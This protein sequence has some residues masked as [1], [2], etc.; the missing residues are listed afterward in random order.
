MRFLIHNLISAGYVVCS[1]DYRMI[2]RGGRIAE[3][4]LDVE[5]AWKWWNIQCQ[6]WSLNVNNVSLLGVSAGATLAMLTAAN[7]N[8]PRP[9]KLISVFGVYDFQHLQGIGALLPRLLFQ[10]KK[11]LSLIQEQQPDCPTLLLHG[12]ADQLVPINLA[13]E[14]FSNRKRLGLPTDLRVYPNAPHGFFNYPS[15]TINKAM[16]DILCY[17]QEKAA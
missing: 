6:R 16:T 4:C 11:P 5:S 17:L 2:F 12:D 15:Q 9:S 7:P 10:G 1:I 13:H 3:S 8:V 14:L